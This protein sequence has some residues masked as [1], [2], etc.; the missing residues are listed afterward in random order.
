MNMKDGCTH[1]DIDSRNNDFDELLFLHTEV[2]T[3]LN[4]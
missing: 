1:N 3:D 2:S 4:G